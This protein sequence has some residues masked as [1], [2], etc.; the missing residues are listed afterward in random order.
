GYLEF[1]VQ[2]AGVVTSAL[3]DMEAGARMGIRGPL[4]NHWPISYL[5]GKQIVIV[6]GGFAF[7]TL[8]SLINYMLHEKNR[9]RFGEIIVVYGARMRGL[10]YK[11]TRPGEG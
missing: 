1:T 7:T 3:H 8:R 11:R 10:P 5:E 9:P 2:K 4:G 6:G